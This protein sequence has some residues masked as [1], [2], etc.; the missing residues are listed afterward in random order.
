MSKEDKCCCGPVVSTGC[1]TETSSSCCGSHPDA[2]KS[3]VIDFLYIDLSVCE[4]CQ[5]TGSTLDEAI[6]DVKKILEAAGYDIKVNYVHVQTE[7]QAEELGFIS[8]PTIRISGRDIQ[9]DVKETLCESCGDLCGED[10][11]CRVWIYEGKEYTVPPKPMIVNAILGSIYGNNSAQDSQK[12]SKTEV[13]PNLK[14]IFSKV[15]R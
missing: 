14:K 6:E 12:N 11:D 7:E 9:M 10:I 2:Q 5:R 3:I 4:R 15:K 1:C 8:S 13:P